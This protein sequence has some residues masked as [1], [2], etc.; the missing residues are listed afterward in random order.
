MGELPYR[1]YYFVELQGGGEKEGD[2][3]DPTHKLSGVGE[4]ACR[5]VCAAHLRFPH[6]GAI[7]S[8][9]VMYSAVRL[10]RR[11]PSSIDQNCH[12]ESLRGLGGRSA[13]SSGYPGYR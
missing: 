12:A 6:Q 11:Q 2:N 7:D 9:M 8:G 3:N 1:T 5:G 13:V 10:M 4:T